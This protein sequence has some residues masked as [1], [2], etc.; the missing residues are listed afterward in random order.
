MHFGEIDQINHIDNL[1][2]GG[3]SELPRSICVNG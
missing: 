1:S 3:S 2:R